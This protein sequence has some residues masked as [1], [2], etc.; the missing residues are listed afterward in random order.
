M[1]NIPGKLRIAVDRNFRYGGNK[2]PIYFGIEDTKGGIHHLKQMVFEEEDSL[3]T[4]MGDFIFLQEDACQDL[5][6]DLYRA[7]FRASDEIKKD[8]LIKVL[9]K[10]IEK[11]D[12]WLDE[13][14]KMDNNMI[15]LLKEEIDKKD[16]M[17]E[18]LM[19]QF[20]FKDSVV[21]GRK[22]LTD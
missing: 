10:E 2:F 19:N 13:W 1:I 20:I 14:E 22:I 4:T 21:N 7:G 12:K 6:N 15:K 16:K 3:G 9:Q 11:R 8:D 17:I 18:A 5:I